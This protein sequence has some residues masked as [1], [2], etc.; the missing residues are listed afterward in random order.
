MTTF[1]DGTT[2]LMPVLV[3]GYAASRAS[4]NIVH[5][6]IGSN[7]SAVALQPSGLR[8]GSLSTLWPTLADAFAFADFLSAASLFTLTDADQPAVNMS[9]VVTDTIE[10]ALDDETRVLGTVSFS[11]QEVTG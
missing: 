4:R 5:S 8:T 10:P 11:F 6:I 2:T 3:N 9:F 1:S 7:V